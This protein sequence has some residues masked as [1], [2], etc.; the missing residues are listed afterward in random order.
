MK[1]YVKILIFNIEKQK[2]YILCFCDYNFSKWIQQDLYNLNAKI[3]DVKSL[4]GGDSHVLKSKYILLT[5]HYHFSKEM[6][7]CIR[8]Y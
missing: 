7:W 3:K 6:Y 1:T 5:N 4:G 8:Q 2:L